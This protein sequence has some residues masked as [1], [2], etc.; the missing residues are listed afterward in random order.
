MEKVKIHIFEP[1]KAE[2]DTKVSI[3]LAS[4]H[5]A[6][7]VLPKKVKT[8]LDREGI[9]LNGLSELIGKKSKKGELIEIEN[10]QG[11]L[12]ILVE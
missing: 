8:A 7:N 5:V 4:L 10:A 12:S 1:G 3:P 11:K 2:A 6:I 9:E